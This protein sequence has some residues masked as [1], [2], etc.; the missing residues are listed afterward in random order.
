MAC[1]AWSLSLPLPDAPA[2]A[3]FGEGGAAGLLEVGAESLDA[4]ADAAVAPAGA[5]DGEGT[6]A[7]DPHATRLP[8]TGRR[9]SVSPV[10]VA[11]TDLGYVEISLARRSTDLT[12][13]S[14][15]LYARI[16]ACRS[17]A[18]PAARRERAAAKPA[19]TGLYGSA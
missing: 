5:L 14:E 1:R 7:S 11:I 9:P 19:S 18:A 8:V 6:L 3:T 15:W 13:S 2:A 4:A 17:V 16:A 12:Y 10:S